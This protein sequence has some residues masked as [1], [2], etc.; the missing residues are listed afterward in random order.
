VIKEI[1]DGDCGNH[2]GGRSLAH[3]VI[4]QGYYWPKM[5]NDAKD[6][7]KK[8]SQCQMFALASNRPSTDLYTLRNP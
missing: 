7:A 5:F 2:S 6:Y 3:K 1:H 4:N 8:C